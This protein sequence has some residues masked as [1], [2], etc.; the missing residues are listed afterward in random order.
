MTRNSEHPMT[1]ERSVELHTEALKYLPGGVNS[2]FRLGGSPVPL[3]FERGAGA[4]LYDAD[5]NSFIDYALGNGPAIL[6]HAPL[7]VIRAVADSLAFGQTFADQHPSEIALARR[8]CELVPCADRVRFSLSGSEAVQAALRLARASTGRPKILRFEGHY[9]GWLDSI[10]ASV[11]PSAVEAGPR[12]SPNVHPESAGQSQASLADMLVL[13]WN[14]LALFRSLI[15]THYREIAG[16]IMEPIACNTGV[17]LPQPGYLEGV[18]EL[19]T[20][21]NIVLIFDEVITGFRVGLRGAQGYLNVEPDLAV[22]AKALGGGFPVSCLAGHADIMEMAVSGGAVLG[23]TFNA[24]LVSV[25]AAAATLEELSRDDGLALAKMIELGEQLRDGLKA[26]S[27]S[28]RP[29]NV[30]GLG[31]VFHLAFTD[32]CEILDYRD[33]LDTDVAA[34]TAFVHQMQA[35]GIR[36]TRRGTWFLSTA[37]TREHIDLT[38]EAARR[39]LSA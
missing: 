9:H 25:A 12:E 19:C 39:I 4:R 8:V 5:G 31:S 37:H 18:R 10:F 17:L 26:F 20:R 34:R 22:F 11:H 15:E 24:N 28:K 13:P 38:L 21:Y 36:I 2:N 32:K 14:D 35:E 6:G 1:F 27:T 30:Q 29:L 16:V 23:G 3:F 7:P 33:Y